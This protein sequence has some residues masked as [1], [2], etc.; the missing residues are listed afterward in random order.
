[1]YFCL[2]LK[3]PVPSSSEG[4]K[5]G[6]AFATERAPSNSP[7]RMRNQANGVTMAT[8]LIPWE[9]ESI[10]H[11]GFVTGKH[12]RKSQSPVISPGKSRTM[13]SL[14]RAGA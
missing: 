13:L 2:L 14:K 9:D 6:T 12:G 3:R 4:E 1:M 7:R 8:G 11:V 10:Q 5:D